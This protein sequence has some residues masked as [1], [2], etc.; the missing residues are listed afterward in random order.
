MPALRRY[1]DAVI[2]MFHSQDK[3]E[4]KVADPTPSVEV[5][6]TPEEAMEAPQEAAEAAVEAMEEA[7]AE[8]APGDPAAELTAAEK[9]PMIEQWPVASQALTDAIG[10]RA[11]AMHADE[12]ALA[13]VRGAQEALAMAEG[14]REETKGMLKSQDSTIVGA[15]DRVVG[16]LTSLRGELVSN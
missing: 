11:T 8:E 14:K 3:K 16:V 4:S 7:P 6:P 1:Y 13:A 10:G 12:Q 5:P 9:A 15:I 2:G